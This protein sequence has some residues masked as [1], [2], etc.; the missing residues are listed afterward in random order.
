GIL[1]EYADA[2][3][4]GP[5]HLLAANERKIAVRPSDEAMYAMALYLW[6]LDPAPSPFPRDARAVRGEAVFEAEGCAKCHQ[7]PLYTDNLLVPVPGF[8]PPTDEFTAKLHISER[9]VD[10]DP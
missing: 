6:S 2:T 5:H 4:F 10:T 3:D 7:P 8:T 1:V 9:S